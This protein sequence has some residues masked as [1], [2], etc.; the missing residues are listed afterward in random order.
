MQKFIHKVSQGTRYNQIYVPKE[1][2]AEFAV[3]DIVEVRLLQKHAQLYYYNIKKS[4]PF[5]EKLIQEIFKL[6]SQERSAEQLF[7]VGSFLSEKV[8]YHDID[9]VLLTS[10]KDQQKEE[11]IYKRLTDKFSLKFHVI[12]IE[13]QSVEHLLKICPL[14]RS[15]FSSCVSNKPF[16]QLSKKQIDKNHLRFLLMLPED[17]L[18]V[19]TVP[20]RVFY[21]ALRRLIAIERFLE[22]RDLNTKKI[23][24]ELSRAFGNLYYL[25]KENEPLDEKI[26]GKVQELIKKKLQAIHKKLK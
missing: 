4:I 15:M 11:E 14:T 22:N 25:L 13:K 20:S 5:K 17:L 26:I 7:I 9:I 3:G 10:Q 8:D 24:E 16:H 21:D 12:A 18:E 6:L 19:K 2:E 1:K 23:Q